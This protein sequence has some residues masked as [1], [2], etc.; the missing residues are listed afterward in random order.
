MTMQAQVS[1]LAAAVG[2]DIKSLATGKLGVSAA[3]ADSA[4]LGGALPSAYALLTDLTNRA[5][6]DTGTS[7][8]A[9][10]QLL[11]MTA[12]PSGVTSQQ[13]HA[14]SIISKYQSNNNMTAPGWI[15]SLRLENQLIGSAQIDKSVVAAVYTTGVGGGRI[16]KALG[17]EAVV[18]ELD[19]TTSINQ[20][21]AFYSAN[22]VAVPGI[23][24]IT[25]AYAFA[26]DWSGAIIKNVGRYIKALDRV[27]GSRLREIPAAPHPGYVADRYYGAALAFN[28]TAQALIAGFGY[29]MLFQCQER[30]TFSKIG[31]RVT[32]GGAAGATLRMGI[33]YAEAGQPSGLIYDS[34]AL[35]CTSIGDVEKSGVGVTLEAGNYILMVTSTAAPQIQSVTDFSARSQWGRSTSTGEESTPLYSVGAGAYPASF[36]APAGWFGIGGVYVDIWMR[37]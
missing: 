26:N 28:P 30:T 25:A 21:G 1:A 12:A 18:A 19:G 3:A 31:C 23:A 20:Y 17:F 10:K 15:V 5:V 36:A 35:A 32:T 24:N 34:G 14:Q 33:Y 8:S 13:L 27:G 11:T 16:D 29:P 37:K 22:L 4:K 6:T 2:A 9:A 7:G